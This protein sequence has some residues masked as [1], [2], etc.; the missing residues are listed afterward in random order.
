M[1]FKTRIGSKRQATDLKKILLGPD[2][3]SGVLRNAPL[4]KMEV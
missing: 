3:S 1:Y 2:N 4:D